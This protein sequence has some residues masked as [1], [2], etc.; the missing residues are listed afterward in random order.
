V[1]FKLYFII[2]IVYKTN[3]ITIHARSVIPGL[4]FFHIAKKFNLKFRKLCKENNKIVTRKKKPLKVNF[5]IRKW[6][7]PRIA[8]WKTKGQK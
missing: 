6:K 4:I 3:Y 2:L 1:E 7:S 8:D 5:Q